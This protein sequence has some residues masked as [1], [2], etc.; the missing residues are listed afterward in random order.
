MPPSL[1]KTTAQRV[2]TLIRTSIVKG[3]VSP[4]DELPSQRALADKFQ[5][6]RSAVR[7]A[8]RQLQAWGLVTVRP[9]GSTR[10]A[11]FVV[12]A[13]LELL[14]VLLDAGG[15]VSHGI[16]RDVHEIR[17]LLLGWAAERAA[18]SADHASIARLQE[19]ATQV[20]APRAR[21]TE[22]QVADYDFFEQLLQIS[23]NRLL[24]LLGK[25]VRDV[26]FR[27][28]TRFLPLYQPGVFDP[29]HHRQA[30]AAI[31]AREVG[32]AGDAMRAHAA[33]G[34]QVLKTASAARRRKA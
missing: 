32:A 12:D 19:L 25:V 28:A 9:Q 20:S 26:Y 14:P 6:T 21:P 22:L 8:M 1:A 13:G 16:M 29:K 30:V 5:V 15:E 3:Q 34:M 11:N 27:D 2:A 7:D 17:G 33:T 4:G 31:R 18:Q 23:G 24:M 10:V